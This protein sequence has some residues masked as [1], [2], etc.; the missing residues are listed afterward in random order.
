MFS[1]I[2]MAV[3]TRF[4]SHKEPNAEHSVHIVQALPS[5]PSSS[6]AAATV[7]NATH[8]PSYKTCR[9]SQ[10]LDLVMSLRQIFDKISFAKWSDMCV[11]ELRIFVAFWAA[12]FLSRVSFKRICVNAK[13]TSIGWAQH[14]MNAVC[15]VCYIERKMFTASEPR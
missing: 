2:F 5:S 14:E 13:R 7:P 15:I 9:F 12:A 10:L 3:M 1:F 11:R 8:F 6:A 4:V